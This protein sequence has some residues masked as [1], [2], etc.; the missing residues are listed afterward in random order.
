MR[1]S[2]TIG[3]LRSLAAPLVMFSFVTNLSVLVSPLFMMHVL[4]RVIPSNNINTLILLILLALLALAA[5]ALVEF[6]RD[7]ALG[8]ISAWVEK[9]LAQNLFRQTSQKSF[10]EPL[11]DI[12]SWRDFLTG[13]AS[14]VLDIPWIP[15]FLVALFL[16]HPAFLGL[17][18]GV[19]VLFLGLGWLSDQTS[20]KSA[21][22]E[23]ATR[24]GGIAALANLETIGPSGSLMSVSENLQEQYLSS[25]NHAAPHANKA[26]KMQNLFGSLNRLVRATMQIGSL[27]LGAY[28]V[29]IGQLSAGGMIGASI[30]LGKAAG[31]IEG[32]LRLIRQRKPLLESLQRLEETVAEG[33]QVRTEIADLSG[34]IKAVE[35]T[36]PKGGGLAPRIDRISFAMKPGECIAIMG[37]SGSG[38]ST[39]IEALSGIAPAPIG[40]CFLDETDIRTLDKET[41]SAAIG[42]V[43]QA[44]HIF[45]GTIAQN[46]ARFSSV[47]DDA[48]VLAAARKAGIHGL[49]SA[50]PE[51]YESDLSKFPYLLSA[52]QKQRLAFAR[53][54]YS[55]PKYLFMDEPN[56]LLDHQGERQMADAIY[57]L[58][59]AGTTIV[60]SA[61]RLGIVNLADRIIIL[62]NGRIA[63]IGPRAEIMSR[64]AN[65][66][67]RIR[68]PVS[69][70]AIQ[71]LTDWVNRQ[72]VRE[73]DDT[74]K[75]QA[76]TVASELYQ[77]ARKNGPISPD[78]LLSFEFKFIDDITCAITLSEQRESPVE[79]KIHKVKKIVEMSAPDYE[80]LRGDEQSLA[81][82]MKLASVF[83]HR[84]EEDFSAF[85]ARITHTNPQEARAS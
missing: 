71:D 73:G 12:A 65:G 8:H 22:A 82:V 40:N 28:L 11:R 61:H 17:V 27:S 42:Y 68:V 81:T 30:L 13:N 74:F 78:R 32:T 83:E 51:A 53:A 33:G 43:P 15:L 35:I 36:F 60:M 79:A 64:V 34:A 10:A 46:I 54:I 3:K 55:E 70:G 7:Q 25:L 39:L 77:F 85:H 6:F 66:H 52:G 29:T 72:F 58:K 38:K 76:S 18:L 5:T 20:E 49:I 63:D 26:R 69:G 9:N 31:I 4:D 1:P 37:D 59:A 44:G 2:E 45:P 16:I 50:L 24:K 75:L 14:S 84:C 80:K 19:V 67:R 48:K 21:Q 62:E 23:T 41:Q 47:P 56:A 57:R